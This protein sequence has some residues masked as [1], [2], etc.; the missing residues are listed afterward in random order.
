[1]SKFRIGDPV[2]VTNPGSVWFD[3]VLTVYDTTGGRI[4]VQRAGSPELFTM[5]EHDLILADAEREAAL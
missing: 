1:M 4:W 2:R 5:D 3:E